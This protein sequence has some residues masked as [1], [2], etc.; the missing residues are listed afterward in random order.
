MPL[1]WYDIYILYSVK[2]WH[3]LNSSFKSNKSSVSTFIKYQQTCLKVNQWVGENKIMSASKSF[4]PYVNCNHFRWNAA[5]YTLIP[6]EMGRN[7]IVP[8]PICNGIWIYMVSLRG[9][10]RFVAVND[11]QVLLRTYSNRD[12]IQKGLSWSAHYLKSKHKSNPLYIYTKQNQHF[13]VSFYYFIFHSI[14][15]ARPDLSHLNSPIGNL[16]KV[17]FF[18]KMPYENDISFKQI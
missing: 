16:G 11:N 14:L 2:Y 12:G 9:P 4:H 6:F 17:F 13:M 18:F 5:E 1:F 7:F 8:Y 10:S 15:F 3:I